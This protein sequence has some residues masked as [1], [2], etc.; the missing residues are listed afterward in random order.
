MDHLPLG[1]VC[2]DVEQSSVPSDRYHV[3]IVLIKHRLLAASGSGDFPL[4]ML[5]RLPGNLAIPAWWE[6]GARAWSGEEGL[7]G[8]DR[9]CEKR[10]T[11]V[12]GNQGPAVIQ[13]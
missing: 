12:G 7:R 13:E 11:W 6:A 10:T 8:V 1:S 4:R 3:F 2:R 9:G 5:S